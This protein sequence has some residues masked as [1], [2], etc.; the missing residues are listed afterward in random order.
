MMSLFEFGL[1]PNRDIHAYI[2]EEVVKKGFENEMC[3]TY[4]AIGI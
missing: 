3:G 2:T 4:S 1:R